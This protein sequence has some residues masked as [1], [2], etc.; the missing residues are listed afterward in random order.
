MRSKGI[1]VHEN[2]RNSCREKSVWNVRNRRAAPQLPQVSHNKNWT[3]FRF[4]AW[5]AS[6]GTKNIK[7]KWHQ[8][9]FCF[10]QYKTLAYHC[11]LLHK[12]EC[13]FFWKRSKHHFYQIITKIFYVRYFESQPYVFIFSNNKKNETTTNEITEMYFNVDGSIKAEKMYQ[14]IY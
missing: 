2:F 1:Y 9:Y 6:E 11:P 8:N 10:R 14:T 7:N 13:D 4:T 12:F 3:F 5:S